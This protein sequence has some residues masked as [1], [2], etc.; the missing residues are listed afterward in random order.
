VTV[1]EAW[2]LFGI[3][4]KRGQKADVKKRYLEFV[5]KHHPDKFR[6]PKQKAE[7]EAQLV[8]ANLAWDLLQRHCRW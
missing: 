2:A 5:S 4:K 8:L 7:A 6:A 3:P 1:D